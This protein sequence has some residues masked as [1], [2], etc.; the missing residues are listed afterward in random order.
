MA[1]IIHTRILEAGNS[2]NVLL[3]IFFCPGY[4]CELY[5]KGHPF[6]KIYIQFIIFSLFS[7]YLL[8]AKYKI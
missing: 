4:I 2:G 7:Q 5:L 1:A 6:V 8:S 3:K